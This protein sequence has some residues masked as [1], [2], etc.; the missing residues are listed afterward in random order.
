MTDDELRALLVTIRELALRPW[1][2]PKEPRNDPTLVWAIGRIAGIAFAA[3]QK[4]SAS[5][6]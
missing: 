4:S 3:L 1:P 5:P 2:F 6:Q